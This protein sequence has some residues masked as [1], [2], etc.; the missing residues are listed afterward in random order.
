MT[1]KQLKN[2]VY[3]IFLHE[4]RYSNFEK[5][6]LKTTLRNNLLKVIE[7]LLQITAQMA[8]PVFKRHFEIVTILSFVPEKRGINCG[9]F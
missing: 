8:K 7:K 1:V 3:F 2:K 5:I 9:V 6:I 4:L